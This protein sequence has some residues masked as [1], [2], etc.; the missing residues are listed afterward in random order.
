MN[1]IISWN[2][3]FFSVV[4]ISL[5]Q[6][7]RTALH[8]AAESDETGVICKDLLDKLAT[9]NIQDIEGMTPLHLAAF[10]GLDINVQ[11]LI[12]YGAHINI[13]THKVFYSFIGFTRLSY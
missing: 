8:C 5:S 13:Q 10:R 7:N 6:K 2:L 12:Q 3:Q 4:I 11:L 9:V 1:M